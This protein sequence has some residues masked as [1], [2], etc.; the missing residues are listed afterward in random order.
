MKAKGRIRKNA[1]KRKGL[2]QTVKLGIATNLALGLIVLSVGFA[3]LYPVNGA[4]QADGGEENVYR[5]GKADSNG[6][7]LMFNVY[8]GTDEVE[9]ILDILDL[10][11][12]R[13]TFFVG[14]CWA[15]DNAKLLNEILSRGNELGN[16]GYFHKDHAS[17]NERANREE[18][19]V[20]NE[21]VRLATGKTMTLFAPPSG[22]YG[23]ATLAAAEAL[24]MKT[25]LW[26]RDTVDWRDK[27]A[28]LVYTRATKNISGGEFVLM[29]PTKAT[30]DALNDVISYYESKGL[31][32]ITV[33]ENL[34]TS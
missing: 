32:A 8:E 23:K 25:I 13:A 15:D 12:S 7:S 19:S 5:R 18:I 14:G 9:R 10:H 22:A 20:C 1:G 6:V 16:H 29:H 27:N 26:S 4:V 31:S 33:S 34:G 11:G 17:L 24:N 3:C 28:S 2:K 21:F 30:A